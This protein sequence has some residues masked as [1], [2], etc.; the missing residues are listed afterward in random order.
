MAV[1]APTMIANGG[2]DSTGCRF[3]VVIVVSQT[4][5]VRAKPH[6]LI[7]AFRVSICSLPPPRRRNHLRVRHPRHPRPLRF[8]RSFVRTIARRRR[9]LL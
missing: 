1:M 3:V 2:T 9:V 6:S 7:R 5:R 4:F 8:V